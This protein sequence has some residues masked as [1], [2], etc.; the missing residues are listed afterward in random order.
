MFWGYVIAFAAGALMTFGAFWA[1]IWWTITSSEKESE[2]LRRQM[3]PE[4]Y[5]PPTPDEDS[6]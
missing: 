2:T 1:L 4:K 3:F 5:G 6:E